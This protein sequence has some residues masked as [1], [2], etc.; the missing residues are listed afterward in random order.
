MQIHSLSFVS[1]VLN[2]N[3]RFEF[4]NQKL[5]ATHNSLNNNW[6]YYDFHIF[7]FLVIFRHMQILVVPWGLYSSNFFK[8]NKNSHSADLNVANFHQNWKI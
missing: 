6:R 2:N 5:D 3:S 8:K 7:F 4:F 1:K